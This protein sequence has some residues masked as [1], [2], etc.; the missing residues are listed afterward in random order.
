M[1]DLVQLPENQVLLDLVHLQESL[2]LDLVLQIENQALFGQA[3]RQ[4]SLLSDL[5]LQIENQVQR[6]RAHR[7]EN[8]VFPDRVQVVV[9]EV[10]A[11][12]AE[13]L[14]DLQVR[15]LDLLQDYPEENNLLK[16]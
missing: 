2:L 15:P 13:T 7:P 6:D 8:Q 3:Q 16:E 10:L 12:Q 14:Q 11:V 4:E 1:R 5:V 9:I